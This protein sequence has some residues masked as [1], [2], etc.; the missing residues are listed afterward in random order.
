MRKSG[1]GVSL[2]TLRV[3]NIIHEQFIWTPRAACRASKI[4]THSLGCEEGSR[5]RR[6]TCRHA[7]LV[8]G[9]R[10]KNR[11]PSYTMTCRLQVS[12]EMAFSFRHRQDFTWLGSSQGE[13]SNGRRTTK[14][15]RRSRW[16]VWIYGC[17][18]RV[19][20]SVDHGRT[21]ARRL[22][23]RSRVIREE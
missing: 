18:N 5:F 13:E 17:N 14:S 10:L 20:M 7:L 2:E 1:Q 3:S 11:V 16:L 12:A 22:L 6:Y 9:P 8:G 21:L 23:R 15:T 4:E 19:E